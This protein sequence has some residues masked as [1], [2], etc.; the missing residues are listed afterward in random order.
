MK[1]LT[2][3][4]F[5]VT[6]F[7]ACGNN[8]KLLA[9][10]STS[11]TGQEAYETV[12]AGCHRDGL[13]NAPKTGDPDAWV[14]RSWLWESVL[15]EHARAGYKEMPAKGG[16]ESLHEATVTKAAEYMM[17]LTYPDVPRG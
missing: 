16:D 12:C 3:L 10:E 2:V 8:D 17:S 9:S 4:L 7:A 15:F 6:T 14:G 5:L 1:R 13:N 11:L